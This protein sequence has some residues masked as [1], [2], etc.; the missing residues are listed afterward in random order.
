MADQESW[1]QYFDY[2]YKPGEELVMR[3]RRPALEL[4]PQEARGHMLAARKEML[5]AFRSF[6]DAA[7]RRTDERQQQSQ[8]RRRRIEVE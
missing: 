8:T 5:L 4:M 3:F 7:I 1:R 6:I 2:E